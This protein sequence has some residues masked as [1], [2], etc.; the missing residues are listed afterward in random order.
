M[1]VAAVLANCPGIWRPAAPAEPGALRELVAATPSQLPEAYLAL[2]QVSDGGEG[3]LGVQPCWCCLWPARDVHRFHE[4]YEVPRYAPG[5]LAFAS[6]GGGE[7]LA[8]DLRNGPPY[9]IVS[10]PCIGMTLKE[11]R[12]VAADFESFVYLLGRAPAA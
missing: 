3:D 11:A 5:L 8:F 1:D 2:L 7:L 12:L 4:E 9:P 10:V 6:N